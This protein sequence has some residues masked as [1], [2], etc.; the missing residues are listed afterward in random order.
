MAAGHCR[1]SLWSGCSSNYYEAGTCISIKLIESPEFIHGED[2]KGNENE[3]DKNDKQTAINW[4]SSINEAYKDVEEE[5]LHHEML[6]KNWRDL[7]DDNPLKP[8]A[9]GAYEALIQ[10]KKPVGIRDVQINAMG[11]L[12]WNWNAPPTPM[13][14][15]KHAVVAGYP[16]GAL[17]NSDPK[18]FAELHSKLLKLGGGN[19]KR[20]IKKMISILDREVSAMEAL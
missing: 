10:L 7:S 6:T 9:F 2:V 17:G 1:F 12:D 19:A 14:S 11:A 3:Q 20:G 18:G 5:P 16:S 8:Y 4:Y 15:L 13:R